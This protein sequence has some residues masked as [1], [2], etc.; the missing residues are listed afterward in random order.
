MHLSAKQLE[1]DAWIYSRRRK[2]CK[3]W[4]LK[5]YGMITEIG[6]VPFSSV[7]NTPD[8]SVLVHGYGEE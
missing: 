4:R 7:S 3:E 1:I 2:N 6:S 5:C 8:N